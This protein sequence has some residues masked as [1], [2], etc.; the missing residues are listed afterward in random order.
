[1]FPPISRARAFRSGFTL[2]ELL[3]VIAIIAILA[4]ILF[5]V[6]A[7]ARENARRSSCQSNLKQMS[8]AWMQ[9]TQDNDEAAVPASW[10]EPSQGFHL[11]NGTGQYAGTFDYTASPMWPYMKNAQFTGCP[12]AHSDE[13]ADWGM[14]DYGYNQLYVGGYGPGDGGSR[15]AASPNKARMTEKPA[16]LAQLQTPSQTLL[17]ADSMWTTP[18][19]S[20]SRWPWLYPPSSGAANGFLQARHLE[21]CNIAFVDGH[22]KAMKLNVMVPDGNGTGQTP[23]SAMRGNISPGGTLTDEYWSGDGQP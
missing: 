15:V 18:T 22:V 3:I 16:N 21:T 19:G 7:R 10:Y 1:M 17:F 8:L 11:W 5:P 6:F 12:S 14:T 20:H 13:A 9:Y 2:V 23:R 4:A